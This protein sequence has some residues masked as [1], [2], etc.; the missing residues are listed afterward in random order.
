[1]PKMLF[2]FTILHRG[3]KSQQASIR[4]LNAHSK[5]CTLLLQE[6]KEPCLFACFA[7]GHK[8]ALVTICGQEI[9]KNK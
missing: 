5:T 2:P 8:E 6:G 1:M 9:L 4:W 3:Q 7:A